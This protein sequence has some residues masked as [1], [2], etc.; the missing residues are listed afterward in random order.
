[1]LHDAVSFIRSEQRRRRFVIDP[2]KSKHVGKLDCATGV[3]LIFTA[4]VTPF[5]VA[6]LPSPTDAAEPLFVI[7][8][9]VDF[10]FTVDM[11]LQFFLMYPAKPQVRAR[12]RAAGSRDARPARPAR[13]GDE[14]DALPARHT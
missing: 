12:A 10:I 1:M 11:V 7:N 5:E 13:S 8:R 4:I 9:V 6:L 2:R 14:R 3:C